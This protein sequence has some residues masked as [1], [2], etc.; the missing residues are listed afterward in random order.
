MSDRYILL[1][2]TNEEIWFQYIETRIAI[3]RSHDRAVLAQ[4]LAI[5]W[6][7]GI[8]DDLG[9]SH[10]PVWKFFKRALVAR[11]FGK[12]ENRKFSPGWSYKDALEYA[13]SFRGR[14]IRFSLFPEDIAC[15]ALS[16]RLPKKQ[17]DEWYDIISQ[18]DNSI[19]MEMFPEASTDDTICFRRYT[20]QFGETIIYEA[21]TGQAMF[22]FEQ[23][24]GEHPV[25]AATKHDK[26]SFVFTQS[27]PNESFYSMA[28][29]IETKLKHLIQTHDITLSSKCFGLCRKLGI[30][31]ISIEGYFDPT[32]PDKVL[33]VDL[34]LPF[35]FVFML[36]KSNCS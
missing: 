33:I 15:H 30:E 14:S 13:N 6:A 1:D 16:F 29:E 11:W 2:P 7:N 34:D 3:A 22:V 4:S 10:T 17:Q 31:Q 20:T 5:E 36:P 26:E 25:V 18:T 28:E 8:C 12:P 27:L 35:D 19:A 21:G 9:I 32:D 23:E 24:R